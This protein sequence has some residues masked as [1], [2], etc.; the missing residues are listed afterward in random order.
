MTSNQSSDPTL[1]EQLRDVTSPSEFAEPAS[2]THA[3]KYTDAV[4]ELLVTGG[5]DQVAMA[6]VARWIRQVPSAVHRFAGGRE[7][8]LTMVVGKFA[9]RWRRWVLLPPFR[10]AGLPIRLPNRPDEVHAIR[11]WA[12]LRESPRARPELGA[13]D[14]PR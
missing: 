6:P 7:G 4:I 5:V 10:D 3:A 12:A 13:R 2:T 11:V 1:W 8:F 9:G 14:W